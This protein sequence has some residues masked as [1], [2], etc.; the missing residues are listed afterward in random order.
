MYLLKNIVVF[1]VNFVKKGISPDEFSP[2]C[3]VRERTITVWKHYLLSF[4]FLHDCQT[5]QPAERFRTSFL[6]ICLGKIKCLVELLCVQNVGSPQK[7]WL[8][9]HNF[10][11]SC[12][13]VSSSWD[14]AVQLENFNSGHKCKL[15]KHCAI[16]ILSDCEDSSCLASFV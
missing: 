16:C 3:G 6:V 2:A 8:R 11:G 15:D 7:W 14:A 12:I 5:V 4:V 1:V 9:R 10:T 13:Y